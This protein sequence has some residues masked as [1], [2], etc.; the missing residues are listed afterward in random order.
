MH[1]DIPIILPNDSLRMIEAA[2]AISGETVEQFILRSSYESA[3]KIIEHHNSDG[4][5][6]KS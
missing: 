5:Y 1:E 4:S 3:V 2:A 6:D